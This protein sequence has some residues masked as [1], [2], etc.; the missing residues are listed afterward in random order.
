[1]SLPG[2]LTVIVMAGKHS[3]GALRPSTAYAPERHKLY[4]KIAPE[5]L[6]G[7]ET[8]ERVTA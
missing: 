4:P 2:A 7:F 1:M 3:T 5:L 8:D 6:Y